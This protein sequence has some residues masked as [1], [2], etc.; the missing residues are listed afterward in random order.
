MRTLVLLPL[1]LAIPASAAERT[2]TIARDVYTAEA[3]LIAVRGDSAYL[4]IDG[5]VE[6]IPIERLSARDQQ[7]IASLSLAPISPG[8]ATDFTGPIENGPTAAEPTTQ[9]EMPLPGQPDPQPAVDRDAVGPD[10]AP[11]YGGTPIDPQPLPRGPYRIDQYGRMI[12]PQPGMAANYLEPQD[13]WGNNAN[14]NDR[15]SRWS[16]Q[17][18]AG[19]PAAR[20][21]RDAEDDGGLLGL[22][23]RRTDRQRAAAARSR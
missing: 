12:A 13:T 20:S 11:A 5:K 23:A 22:R 19:N 17:Q 14:P 9:E 21:Q 3:E 1:L 8:P 15:R 6:E 18:G 4:K 7:Y 10:L 16:P 2:W